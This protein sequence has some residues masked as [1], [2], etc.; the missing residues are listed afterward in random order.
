M[1]LKTCSNI[2]QRMNVPLDEILYMPIGKELL[3]RRGQRPVVTSR[4]NVCENETYKKVT[5]KYN[6]SILKK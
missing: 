6:K 3:F 5:A 2:S 1:D 4:Y